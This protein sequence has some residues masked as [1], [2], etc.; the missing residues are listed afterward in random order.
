[1][2]IVLQIK[3]D[4][5]DNKK[6]FQSKGNRPLSQV[7]KFQQAWEGPKWTSFN[8]SAVVTWDPPA[9][10]EQIDTHNWK[11]YI[12]GGNKPVFSATSKAYVT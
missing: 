4:Q 2:S 9:K 6:A 3:E 8:R 10:C 1:M 5:Q 7:N 12:P 11:H